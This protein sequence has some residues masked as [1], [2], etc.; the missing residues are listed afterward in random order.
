MNWQPT[1]SGKGLSYLTAPLASD[2]VVTGPGHLDLW[3]R[4]TAVDADLEVV[5]TEVYPDGHEVEVQEGLLRAGDRSIDTSRTDQFRIEH[6]YD[7]AHY[8]TLPLGQ[9]SFLQIPLFS[10]AHPFRAGSKLRITVTTPG[11]NLPIW[12]FV[13][14]PFGNQPVLDD[15]AHGGDMASKLVLPVT[16][17]LPTSTYPADRPACGSLRGQV[18]RDYT[19]LANQVVEVDP[20][21][22]LAPT[23]AAP[24]TAGGG[25]A[26]TTTPGSPVSGGSGSGGSA[27]GA[28]GSA[29]EGATAVT[30]A[31]EFTG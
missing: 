20:P 21:T 5:M 28:G 31:P 29:V 19:T 9:F 15:V 22:T 1:A 6:N 16:A 27:S 30:A 14:P 2:M 12:S 13:N 10:V 7:L 23:T 4:S 24:T 25:F 11:G 18:C 26:S 17:G 8:Q 3:L